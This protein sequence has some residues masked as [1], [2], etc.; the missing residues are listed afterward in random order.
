[1]EQRVAQ[2]AAHGKSDHD[3]Q[4]RRVNVRR[5]QREQKVGRA[6]DVQRREE[7]VDGGRPGE[8]DGEEARREGRGRRGVMGVLDGR[9]LLDN[10]A[11]LLLRLLK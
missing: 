2:Q 6:R 1:M 9:Q 5:A 8:E 10:W 3:A 7:G 4:R 11:R